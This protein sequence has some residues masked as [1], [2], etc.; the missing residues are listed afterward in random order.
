[1]KK[2]LTSKFFISAGITLIAAA[3]LITAYNIL[4]GYWAGRKAEL[5]FELMSEKMQN[6]SDD[7][8]D[9]MTSDGRPL[10]EKYPEMA[11]PL[12]EIDGEFYAGVLEIPSLNIKLPVRNEFSYKGLKTAPCIYDG[13]VYLNNMIV[14]AHNYYSHFGRLKNL[15]IG[16]RVSFTDGDGNLFMYEV[17]DIMQ[18]DGRDVE[19]MKE[20]EW[21]MTLFTC[22]ISGQSRVAVRMMRVE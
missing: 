18:I 11:M 19:G 8:L 7:S 6:I 12:V 21:N 1:M 10:Y 3:L 17:S 4:D 14:A 13:S 5:A 16:D 9:S 22:T 15:N 20:G 2:K